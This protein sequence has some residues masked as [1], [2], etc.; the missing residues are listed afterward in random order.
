MGIIELFLLLALIGFAAWAV[1]RFIPMPAG[2]ARLIY[3][4]AVFIGILLVLSA[5]GLLGR[6]SLGNVPRL[7]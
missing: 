2:M 3:G 7:R 1:V 5:F 6:I 4:A